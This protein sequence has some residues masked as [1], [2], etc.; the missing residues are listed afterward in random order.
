MINEEE[1]GI[2]SA[3]EEHAP[4]A[5]SDWTKKLRFDRSFTAKLILSDEK[6]KGFYAEIAAELL[7]YERVKSRTGWSGVSFTHG[8]ERLA[9]V[10]IVGKTLCVYLAVEPSEEGR[11]KAKDVSEVKSRLKTPSLFKIK[12]EGAKNHAIKLIGEIAK[13]E[14]LTPSAK[15]NSAVRVASFKNDSFN[16][17]VTRGL[18]K[19]VR[20]GGAQ[21]RGAARAAAQNGAYADTVNTVDSL[22]SRHGLYGELLSALAEGEGRAK[23]SKRQMLRSIDEIWVRAIEDCIPSLDELIRNPNHFIAE[24]EEVLPIEKTKRVSGRSIAHLC[25]HTDYLSVK[26]GELTPTRMLNVFREDSLLTYENKFLNTLIS[27][28]YLFVSRRYKVAKDYGADETVETFEFESNFAHGEGKGKISFCVEYSEKRLDPNAKNALAGTDLWKRAERLNAVVTGYVNSAFA[29][30]MDRN[31]VKPPILRTN[32]ILKNK[33]FRECLA[34]WEFIE[35]YDDAGYGIVVEE[36]DKALSDEY[37][38]EAYSAAAMQYVAFR[39]AIDRALEADESETYDVTPDFMVEELEKEAYKEEFAEGPFGEEIDGDVTLA[40]QV[41]LEADDAVQAEE[42]GF[43]AYIKKSF[44]AKLRM[45][46][47][48][49][50][51]NFAR[52]ANAVL[53]Y[54]K[55]RMRHSRKHAAFYRGRQPLL[56]VTVSGNS[57]KAFFALP[58][59]VVPAKFN[60]AFVSDKKALSDTP[61]CLRVKGARSVKHAE[62]AIALLAETH[63][64]QL[65]KKAAEPIVAADYGAETVGE[66]LQKGW[67]TFAKKKAFGSAKK[68]QTERLARAAEELAVSE[69]AKRAEP[70]QAPQNNGETPSKD[71]L[72]VAKEFAELI[73]PEGNYEHPEKFGLDDAS[74]FISDALAEQQA[75]QQAEQTEPPTEQP[76]EQSEEAVLHSG[77]AEQS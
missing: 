70:V 27:R 7:R 11:Y 37:V 56:R 1:N 18:I 38:K 64:L 48:R 25:R 57:L 2:V 54:S 40:L 28:L 72:L 29:K 20:K 51:E 6:T 4:V 76:T 74:A 13:R 46:N 41:A 50:K 14:I 5:F 58:Q 16:N 77:E 53:K 55:V 10:S 68:R 43:A 60:A 15:D 34:L 31:F 24:S 52:L 33:Y 71:A 44:H 26:D 63:G 66:L 61:V 47:D 62:E 65:A 30:A 8:R 67:V 75:E 39:Q 12:S 36:T 32:A 3:T 49:E 19:I 45:A 35:S 17:L 69:S 73:R 23:L 21:S 9:F 42:E 59:E 22:M